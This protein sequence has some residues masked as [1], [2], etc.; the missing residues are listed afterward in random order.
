MTVLIGIIGNDAARFHEFTASTLRLRR[1]PDSH[2]EFLIG[3]DW[4]GARNAL[5]QQCLDGDFTH[6][7]FMDDDHSFSPD[8]LLQLLAWDKPLVVPM[9]LQRV[10]PFAPVSY[11]K[12]PV[13]L[14]HLGDFIPID[15]SNHPGGGLVELEAGGA[16]GM[17]IHRDVLE[18]TKLQ[19][20]TPEHSTTVMPVQAE[21]PWFEYTDQSEDIVFC[22]K[23]K[24][25]GFT[26]WGDLGA[27]LGHI[28]TAVVIPSYTEEHGWTTGLR[29]GKDY[30]I[31]VKQTYDL[32]EDGRREVAAPVVRSDPEAAELIPLS[33]RASGAS[34]EGNDPDTG[35]AALSVQDPCGICGAQSAWTDAAGRQGCE[36]HPPNATEWS[37]ERI[38]IWQT[39]DDGRV[40]WWWRALDWEGKIM[41]K[42]SGLREDQVIATAELLFPDTSVHLIARE[43]DDSRIQQQYGPPTRLWN[44]EVG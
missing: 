5:A 31:R 30:D 17:L 12:S 42:D 18:A 9:C 36:A 25:A 40:R 27:R 32:I 8:L 24:A 43:I 20:V 15:L 33:E 21:V 14:A 4:C 10:F 3:G 37:A 1:P 39:E 29:V 13:E 44:R 2:L 6:L 38:E 23:A 16:A 7:W 26:L 35:A 19:W 22:E 28:T 41:A 34:G 11:V